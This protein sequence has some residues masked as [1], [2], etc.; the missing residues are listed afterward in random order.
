MQN[1]TEFRIPICEKYML[2]I[3]EA[4]ACFNIGTKRMRRYAEESNEGCFSFMMGNKYLICRHRFEQYLDGLML[5]RDGL[6]REDEN[7]E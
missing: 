5:Q 4:A 7:E 1:N 6:L 3:K 2:T